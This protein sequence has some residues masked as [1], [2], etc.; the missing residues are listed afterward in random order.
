LVN[1]QHKKANTKC[2]PPDDSNFTKEEEEFISNDEKVL[3]NDFDIMEKNI[4]NGCY[5]ISVGV[6]NIVKSMYVDPEFPQNQ[7]IKKIKRKDKHY[8]SETKF[9]LGSLI[10]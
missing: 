7:T 2:S 8:L 6:V 4:K 9:K 1:I 3:R 5:D 10:K